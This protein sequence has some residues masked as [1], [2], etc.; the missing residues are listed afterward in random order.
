MN[1]HQR[2]QLK[3]LKGSFLGYYSTSRK[4]CMICFMLFANKCNES[5]GCYEPRW[6]QNTYHL[7]KGAQELRMIKLVRV[8]SR[9][10]SFYHL[11]FGPWA[12]T[13]YVGMLIRDKLHP[14]KLHELPFFLSTSSL[15]GHGAS[16]LQYLQSALHHRSQGPEPQALNPEE[17]S[18]IRTRRKRTVMNWMFC[19]PTPTIH[20]LKP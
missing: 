7:P 15:K 5:V 13:P 14:G 19:P 10:I 17:K 2:W 9:H 16:I 11:R 18:I 1:C 4:G 12:I 6:P 3:H 20:M 8:T